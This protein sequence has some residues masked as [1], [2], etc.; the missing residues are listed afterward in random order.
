LQRVAAC[1]SAKQGT[2]INTH[3]NPSQC[4]AVCCSMLYENPRSYENVLRKPVFLNPAAH[5]LK[6]KLYAS[7]M[8]LFAVQYAATQCNTLQHTATHYDTLQNCAPHCN[9][10]QYTATHCN[11]LPRRLQHTAT[12]W[13]TLHHTATHCTATRCNTLHHNATHCNTLQ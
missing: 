7:C 10:L 13:N 9:T 2:S 3:T 11:T 8:K 5:A 6:S 4:A 12:R 1:C